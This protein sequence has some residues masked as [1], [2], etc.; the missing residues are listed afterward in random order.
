[1]KINA[2][3]RSARI[4]A[5]FLAVIAVSTALAGCS[6]SDST[7]SSSASAGTVALPSAFKG[8][9]LV[10]PAING[11]PPY[12]YTENGKNIGISSD[13]ATA[14]GGPLGTTVTLKP[15]SFEN[16]LLGVNRGTYFGAFGADVT[17][18]REKVYDQVSFLADHYEFMSLK[19]TKL[20]TSM[21]SLCG[22]T[23]SL[24]AADSSIPVLQAE[25][26]TCTDAGKKAITIQTFAD[27]G[28]ATL[29]VSSK[30]ADATTS[31]LTNLSY[32]S[33][34]APDT[35]QLGGP[36]YQYVLIGIATK[37]GNG[38]AKALAASI[39][40]L[41]DNGKYTSMLKKYGLEDDAI[42]KAEVQPGPEHHQV[43]ELTHV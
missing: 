23:I 38:M 2:V 36:K 8:K 5:G 27:Q 13:L 14:V 43:K 42:T 7:P 32:I 15:D 17:A 12:A 25:S 4:A 19:A 3:P 24:V 1:M 21:S 22:L 40:E 18:D 26:T 29:A 41:I 34:Q 35:F 16:A 28:A 37:K 33:Q 10:A 31:T 11:Y 39:N 20:G 30:Q 6:S 9:T